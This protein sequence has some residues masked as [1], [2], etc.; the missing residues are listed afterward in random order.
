MTPQTPINYHIIFDNDNVRIEGDGDQLIMELSAPHL[1][2]RRSGVFAAWA[3][4]PIA[5]AKHRDIRIFGGGGEDVVCR[6]FETLSRMWS[7][8][9]PEN[10]RWAKVSFEQ[11]LSGTKADSDEDLMLFSGGVDS[12]Y[13]LLLRHEAGLRQTLLTLHGMDYRTEDVERFEK[14]VEMTDPLVRMTSSNRIFC[15]TNAYDIYRKYGINAGISHG[16]VLASS[17][18]L[19][20]SQFRQGEI[21][22]DTAR[23]QEFLIYPWGT[24]SIS[25]E[26]FKSSSFKMNTANLDLTRSQKLKLISKYPTALNSLSFCKDY[27][28]RPNNCGVCTKCIR[29]KLMF[30]AACGE[31]PDIFADPL[32]EDDMLGSSNFTGH[33]VRAFL[34]DII[35]TADRNGFSDR[36]PGLD[37]KLAELEAGTL[38]TSEKQQ[39]KITK[40]MQPLPPVRRRSWFGKLFHRL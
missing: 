11:P 22:A 34:I 24:N 7:T 19:H 23:Y 3:L 25:N 35:Q 15:R 1:V 12:T 31:I 21:A 18:F 5:M 29:T 20:G 37:K 9:L 38:E 14:L 40:E 2:D 10:F 6:N 27:S 17:L 32:F 33:G 8:W 30:L 13:N 39:P 28:F 26:L 16:F 4:L 36:I